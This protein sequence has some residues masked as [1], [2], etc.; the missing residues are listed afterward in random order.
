[1]SQHEDLGPKLDRRNCAGCDSRRFIRDR[2]KF[3]AGNASPI[4]PE[5]RGAPVNLLRS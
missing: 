3:G 2:L 5:F 4:W 1:M